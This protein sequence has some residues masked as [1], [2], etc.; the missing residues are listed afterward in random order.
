MVQTYSMS[1]IGLIL[2]ALVAL[3]ACGVVAG[4]VALLVNPKTRW[5][6]VL[7]STF[8]AA[9]VLLAGGMFY[10]RSAS[11]EVR[12]SY[13]ELG[14][15]VRIYPAVSS[16]ERIAQA[17]PSVDRVV[18]ELPPASGQGPKKVNSV[19]RILAN[20]VLR[21]IEE[22]ER[23]D[24][25]PKLAE[26]PEVTTVAAESDSPPRPDWVDREPHLVNGV[27]Q[28][29]VSAGP[30]LTLEECENKL[31]EELNKAV[32]EYVKPRHGLKA[33]RR[34]HLPSDY[35]E[36]HLIQ[37]RFEERKQFSV[38]PMV[39]LHVLLGFDRQ[40]AEQ[41]REDCRRLLVQERIWGLGILGTLLLLLLSAVY[42]Y[43]K[44]DL[45]TQGRY[46]WRLR[47]AASVAIAA[48][49]A[50]VLAIAG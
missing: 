19:L 36:G 23:G 21:A 42:G 15:G 16:T 30:Y 45:A 6:A 3:V 27:Y 20:A 22:E 14:P 8:V 2:V 12:V 5:A 47:L 44:V 31:P 7:L 4:G 26:K 33:S 32:A 10:V 13:E 18:V 40:A 9:M 11:R 50:V 17:K 24:N 28:M 1:W 48:V 35:I 29:S 38:G 46:R 34:L 43:L 37:A 25:K 49:I 41:I 39:R